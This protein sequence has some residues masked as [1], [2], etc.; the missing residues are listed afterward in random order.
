MQWATL[1]LA[2]I[3]GLGSLISWLHDKDLL[4]AGEARATATQ[5]RA[6]A[7][8][9]S[10]AYKLREETRAA[11]ALVPPDRSLPNDGFQRGGD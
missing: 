7:D 5:L 8:A 10:K 6:E 9:I 2:L 3:Q 4:T 11:N 1:A